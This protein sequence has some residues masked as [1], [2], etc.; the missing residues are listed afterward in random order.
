MFW[1]KEPPPKLWFMKPGWVTIIIT[2]VV[3][4]VLGPVGAIYQG[5]AEEQ[6]QNT[7]AI[8]QNQLAIK[9]LLTRQ[10]MIL[11]P[12]AVKII[13]PAKTAVKKPIPPAYFQAY[14]QLPKDSQAG[15]KLYLQQLGYDVG[16]LP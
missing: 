1:R 14:I 8:V 7:S 11:A 16:G 12:K 2:L 4:F 15:Y 9:E 6:K 5:I 10:Q 3:I 13:D